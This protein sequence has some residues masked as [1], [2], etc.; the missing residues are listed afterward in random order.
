MAH[1]KLRV[2]SRDGA[3]TLPSTRIVDE[4]SDEFKSSA[5][6]SVESE[7]PSNQPLPPEL[8]FSFHSDACPRLTCCLCFWP[9]GRPCADQAT[10]S[11]TGS[12]AVAQVLKMNLA[13]RL[14]MRGM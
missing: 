12:F 11:R 4:S 10:P 8:L 2:S 9:Q 14:V 5:P 3:G 13:K 6:D 1:A 7:R